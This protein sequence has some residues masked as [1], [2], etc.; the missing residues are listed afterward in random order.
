MLTVISLTCAAVL[1]VGTAAVY[2]WRARRRRAQQPPEEYQPRCC[3]WHGTQIGKLRIKVTMC[4]AA[5]A[6][7]GDEG[8]TDDSGPAHYTR[9]PYDTR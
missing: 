9:P 3:G 6:N 2:A 7:Y 5:G 8:D 4:T 1:V